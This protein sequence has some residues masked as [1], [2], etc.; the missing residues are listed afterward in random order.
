LRIFASRLRDL[1]ASDRIFVSADVRDDLGERAV[2]TELGDIRVDPRGGAEP[3]F[4]LEEL[5]N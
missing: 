2:V 1:A 5:Q 4:A 3:A